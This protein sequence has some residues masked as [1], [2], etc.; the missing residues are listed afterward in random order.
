MF[1]IIFY[2]AAQSQQLLSTD[3][4]RNFSLLKFENLLENKLTHSSVG[5]GYEIRQKGKILKST[6]GGYCVMS[7]DRSDGHSLPFDLSKRVHIA[8]VSKTITALGIAKLVEMGKLSFNSRIKDFLP[9]SWKLHQLFDTTKIVDLLTMTSGLDGILD[10][11]TSCYDSLKVYLEKGP[12]I[13]KIG[14]FNYQNISY[15]LLRIII[16]YAADKQSISALANPAVIALNTT[17]SYINFINHYLFTPAGIQNVLCRESENQPV[18]VYPFPYNNQNGALSGPG[19]NQD[20][21]LSPV[22]GGLGWYMSVSDLSK[23]LSEVFIKRKIIRTE[24]IDQLIALKFPLKIN[25]EMYGQYFGSGGDWMSFS[26]SDVR[27]GIHAYYYFFP[28]QLQ[29]VVFINSG[30]RGLRDTILTSFLEACR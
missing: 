6:S 22:A 25:S 10:S 3:S 21:D 4:F 19:N 16:A 5:W 7:V 23:F 15:G 12:D 14:K 24:V 9:S 27:G 28:G 11:K 18:L 26:A 17:N 1:L 30:P 2:Y 8:S 29:V 13:N 20:G